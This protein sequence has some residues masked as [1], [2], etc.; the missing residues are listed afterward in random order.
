MGVCGGYDTDEFKALEMCC[1]C[2]GGSGRTNDG[3]NGDSNNT[4]V[5]TAG[6]LVDKYDDGCKWYNNPYVDKNECG[7]WDFGEFKAEEMCCGCGGGEI[8]PRL[9]DILN[10]SHLLE[11]TLTNWFLGDFDK[12]YSGVDDWFIGDAFLAT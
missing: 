7:R 6:D 9:E 3:K 1:A 4:C 11:E 12:L 8:I 5:D 2:N 10:D